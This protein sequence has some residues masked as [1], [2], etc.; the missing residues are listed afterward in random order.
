[1]TS[2]LQD[3][4]IF[5]KGCNQLI[6]LA[7]GLDLCLVSKQKWHLAE[8]LLGLGWNGSWL[9]RTNRQDGEIWICDGTGSGWAHETV[10]WAPT[11][12]VKWSCREMAL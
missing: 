8:T 5:S 10:W 2:W 9:E 11:S 12:F 4:F 7:T 6:A 1:M 3:F